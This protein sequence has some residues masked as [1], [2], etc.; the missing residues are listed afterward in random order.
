MSTYYHHKIGGYP[1][2]AYSKNP[3]LSESDR[4]LSKGYIV[5]LQMVF[6]GPPDDGGFDETWP[7]LGFH[8]LVF[9]KVIQGRWDIKY[10]WS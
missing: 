2:L 7:F 1:L 6:P 5:M 4:L 9:V 8:F 10:G 3:I